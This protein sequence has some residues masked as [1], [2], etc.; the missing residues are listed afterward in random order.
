MSGDALE[1]SGV[2]THNL[3]DVHVSF[4]KGRWTALC[5]VSGSGKTSL[6][7]HTLHA[8]SERRWLS[9]LPAWRRFL[10]DSLPR[11]PLE[12]AHGLTPTAALRQETP[13]GAAGTLASLSGLREPLAALWAAVAVPIS[14]ATGE[15]MRAHSPDEAADELIRRFPG[16]RLQTLFKASGGP[17]EWMARGFVR[18][19]AGG[20]G[21]EFSEEP[22]GG[23]LDDLSVVV[24]RLKAEPRMASR[25]AESVAVAYRHGDGICQVEVRDGDGPSMLVGFSNV[26]RC[27]VSG[28]RS[29]R[30]VPGLFSPRSVQGACPACGGSGGGQDDCQVCRGSGLREEA[31]WFRFDGMGLDALVALP[32]GSG[33][34]V[35]LGPGW[36][37]LLSGPCR[38][39]VL[40]I[41]S[42]F[43]SLESLGL[44][45]LPLTRR[46][47]TLSEGEERR[48]RLSALVGSPLSGLTYV[49]DE[50][51]TGLHPRDVGRVHQLL[52]GLCDG[53]ATL[54]VVEHDL[55][56]LGAADHVVET[57]PGPGPQ[58]GRL[59]Y[60]GP[61]SA[62]AGADTPS[63]RWISGRDRPP[64]RPPREGDGS[65]VLRGCSGR[66]LS[67]PLV[68]FPLGALVAVTGV[69]GAGKSSLLQDT[70]AGA[71][72][73]A[74]GDDRPGLPVEGAE[75]SGR[76]DE[77]RCIDVGGEWVRSARSTVATLS[78]MLDELRVLFAALPEAKARGWGATRFSPNAKGGRCERC[79]GLGEER[80][81]L[82]LLPDAWVPCER[83]HGARFEP[84]TL[85]I[86]WKGLNIAEVLDLSLE[87]AAP[88]FSNHPKLGPLLSRLVQAGLGHLSGGRRVQGLSGGEALRLRLAAAVSA[89]QRKRVLW[90]LDEPSRGLHPRD[91][92]ALLSVL[93]GLVECGHGVVFSTH[94]PFL[95][96]RADHL[97]ELGPGAANEGGRLLY[98]GVP[99]G[100]VGLDCP[101]SEAI[102]RAFS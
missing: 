4:P 11:P 22:D 101:S 79:E 13:E 14:P 55:A 35:V 80:V 60:Q 28:L 32:V 83:C 26:P 23:G 36:E 93:D 87:S 61:P 3:R 77:V 67:I 31:R 81:R 62:L 39:L 19:L 5:G 71:L 91:T 1:L 64:S 63:G 65:V 96:S 34:G 88:L 15:I 78:G 24:D 6:A 2:R 41:R 86:R 92:I 52:R 29:I 20:R 68:R 45:Y 53:G 44:G 33:L 72:A 74:L 27:P 16:H 76:L 17:R 50:P 30:P 75:V 46:V 94:D 89:G 8:E 25:L 12:S 97:L 54:V 56:S 51:A 85:E 90:I 47:D 58:G 69:S 10:A 84:S 42:R 40:E 70:L 100:I 9:T 48:A 99:R 43:A 102:S 18:G 38:E 66:N 82:H 73:K 37:G 59:V 49:L 95:A 98:S 7:F 57:G 21:V